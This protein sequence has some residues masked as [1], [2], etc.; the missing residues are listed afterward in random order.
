MAYL[1]NDKGDQI[2]DHKDMCGLV[3]LY[4]NGVFTNNQH[5]NE[6]VMLA[7]DRC[8]TNNQ[9][10]ELVV[11]LTFKEFSN[12]TKQIIRIRL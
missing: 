11:N 12:A 5:G 2:C 10:Q 8:V 9:N 3:A 4:F 6:A 1:L 7:A